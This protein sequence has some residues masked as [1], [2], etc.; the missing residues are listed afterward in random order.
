Q[1]ANWNSGRCK[2]IDLDLVCCHDLLR[3]CLVKDRL[4]PL[5]LV[6]RLDQL[7]TEILLGCEYSQS[8][9]WTLTYSSGIDAEE[10]WFRR[11]YRAL[12]QIEIERNGVSREP[13]RPGILC[14]RSTE[15]REVIQFRISSRSAAL[16]HL[17][18]DVLESHDCRGFEIALLAE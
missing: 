2:R 14:R 5:L 1:L 17:A 4:L 15:D 7:A 18:K 11:V 9:A 16:L 13:P 12:Q 3:C 10:L 6:E 8:L